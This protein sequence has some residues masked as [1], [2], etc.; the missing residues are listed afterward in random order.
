MGGIVAFEMA[1]QLVAAGHDVPLVILIDCSVPVPRVA[2]RAFNELESLASFAADLAKT[3]GREDSGA[4]SN[5]SAASILNRSGTGPSIR[6]NW[7]ARSRQR[8]ESIACAGSTMCSG[9]T[10]WP[11]TAT[12]LDLI[13]AE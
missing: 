10:A 12:S 5:A 8:S 11:S 3:A 6:R 7:A 2:G 13:R 9:R 1:V 4:D